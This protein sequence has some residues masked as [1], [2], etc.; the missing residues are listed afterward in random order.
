[1]SRSKRTIAIATAR[2]LAITRQRL[3]GLRPKPDAKGILQIV[4]DLG[5]LQLD[6]IN[7]VAHSHLL[8]LWSRLGAFD[9]AVLD[10]LL[11]RDR[12]LF[13][14]W[15]HAASIVPTSDFAFHLP[16]MLA[17]RDPAHPKGRD[18]HSW[19]E[20]HRAMR[21]RILAGLR[22][23]GPLRPKDFEDD[24]ATEWWGPGWTSGRVV[25]RMLDV[26]WAQGYIA[27]AKR[28]SMLRLWDLAERCFPEM[29][30]QP[31]LA[32]RDYSRLAVQRSLRALGVGRVGHIREH[33]VRHR[34]PDLA[35]TVRDLVAENILVPV[36]VADGGTALPGEWLIHADDL[37]LVEA[38]EDGAWQP[39]TT[40][41]SPF[42]NLIC[43]RARTELL[44]D[45]FYRVEIYVPPAKRQFGYY[46]LPILH[47]DRL[48]GRIDPV[49]ERKAGWLRIRS[50][51]L[52]SGGKPTR[53]I[54][55]GIDKAV[56]DLA[57]FIG[58]SEIAWPET[59]W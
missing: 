48:I 49:F 55:R 22:E 41:L 42:D 57:S 33:F 52:E 7:A 53:E 26:L 44:F 37:P 31:L 34:Y 17:Y 10:R 30:R 3:T 29:M 19:M 38:L 24:T 18:V 12:Q 35:G 15:A 32:E 47:G 36:A 27:V 58:A 8:V 21:D 25:N 4:Q 23:R 40:L 59:G 56:A 51:H 54:Q 2:R 1:M 45:F 16:L 50:I 46:V 9:R 5:C 13:E 11:W 39:R 20:E 43:D 28:V 6:P 14:Y